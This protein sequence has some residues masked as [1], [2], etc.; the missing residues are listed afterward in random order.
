MRR[1]R[2]GAADGCGPTCLVENPDDCPGTPI[3]V[4]L[5]SFTLTGDTTG[6]NDTVTTSSGAG[7]CSAGNWFGPDHVYAVTAGASGAMDVILQATFGYHSLH[8]RDSCPGAADIDCDYQTSAAANDSLVFDV[9]QGQ[10]Y[11]V[12]VDSWGSTSGGYTLTLD[13]N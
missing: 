10:V 9:V 2:P 1:R 5:A 3:T 7:T 12:F 13:I 8:A 6:A 11:Y 4:G